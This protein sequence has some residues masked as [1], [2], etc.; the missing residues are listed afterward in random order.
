MSD[1]TCRVR[2]SIPTFVTYVFGAL[3]F[4]LM[5][6]VGIWSFCTV[7]RNKKRHK[8]E[9]QQEH[10]QQL[11]LQLQLQVHSSSEEAIYK[12]QTSSSLSSANV[13]QESNTTSKKK[14]KSK[15]PSL[16]KSWFLDVWFRRRCFIPLLTHLIDQVTDVG[17]ILNFWYLSR[18]QE[19]DKSV[20][21]S[22][23]V[24]YLFIGSVFAFIFYRVVSSV[25][26]Y[27]QTKKCYRFLFQLLDL[28]LYRTLWVNYKLGKG[29]PNNAQ[30]WIQSQEAFLEA[31]PQTLIQLYYVVKVGTN[32]ASGLVIFSFTMSLLS[33][34]GKTVSEDKLM[35][36][37]EYQ[38]FPMLSGS[39]V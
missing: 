36:E 11:Q 23:T 25:A 29:K 28:E 14:S 3:Y 17:V 9:Q 7:K 1:S 30:R 8:L 35:F 39:R 37:Q 19:K 13:H 18:K 38:D 20:C 5:L 26:M 24:L 15:Q 10:E 27:N 32:E 34:I 6:A 2:S 31:F 4:S 16:I 33:M 12:Q 21:Q 22:I